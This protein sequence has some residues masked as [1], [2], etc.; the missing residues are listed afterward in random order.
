MKVGDAI[1]RLTNKFRYLIKFEKQYE[2]HSS[3]CNRG[4][5]RQTTSHLWSSMHK[6][7]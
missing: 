4:N 5:Y 3:V 7:T 1:K 6:N 2:K